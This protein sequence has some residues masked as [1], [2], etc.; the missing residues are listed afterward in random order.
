MIKVEYSTEHITVEK[1][2]DLVFDG[3][4][5]RQLRSTLRAFTQGEPRNFVST[6]INKGTSRLEVWRVLVSFYDPNN[7]NTRMDESKAK[8]MADVPLIM[9]KWEDLLDHRFRTLGRAPLDDDQ[10]RSVLLSILPVQMQRAKSS[11]IKGFFPNSVFSTG[12]F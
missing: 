11:N 2:L 9:S 3:E 8:T 1:A 4:E 5:D 10:K 7:D 12:G 6:E